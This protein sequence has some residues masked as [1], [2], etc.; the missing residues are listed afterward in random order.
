M[1]HANSFFAGFVSFFDGF[2]AVGQSR[3]L[4]MLIVLPMI[5]MAI[6]FTLGIIFLSSWISVIAG[7]LQTFTESLVTVGTSL[8]FIFTFLTWLIYVMV[9]FLLMYFFGR[10]L[11]S[12]FYALI[13]EQILKDM[14]VK[15]PPEHGIMMWVR[16]NFHMVIVS[17]IEA[18]VFAFLGLSFFVLSFI[19]PLGV[20][21]PFLFVLLMT[22]DASDFVF[23][24][25]NMGFRSRMKFF[26][27][28]IFYYLGFSCALGLTLMIP[29]L[30]LILFPF[31]VA[32][33]AKLAAQILK[34]EGLHAAKPSSI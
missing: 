22:F 3:R 23:E 26:R 13:A 18:V 8:S 15:N 2:R 30:N 20:L 6:L 31:Y 4:K 34:K 11:A 12:P 14:G 25:L 9:F 28:Y 29:V 19:P 5:L 27:K 32:G 1:S 33:A 24:S 10:V 21:T 17:A 7:Q 16:L